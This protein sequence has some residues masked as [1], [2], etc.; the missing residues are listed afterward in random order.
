MSEVVRSHRE[1]IKGEVFEVL[2]ENLCIVKPEYAGRDVVLCPICLREINKAEILSTG[3]EHI[4]PQSLTKKDPQGLTLEL[5]STQR[6]G[7]TI[8]CRQPRTL[9]DNTLANN[10]CNGYKGSKYDWSLRGML[11]DG[12]IDRAKL[13][14]VHGVAILTMAYLGAFQRF[15]YGYILRPELDPIREQFD[16]PNVPT[17]VWLESVKI[18]TDSNAPQLVMTTG[19]NCFD[20][21]SQMLP[22]QPLGVRFRKFLAE[23]PNGVFPYNTVGTSNVRTLQSLLPRLTDEE[24]REDLIDGSGND[25][26]A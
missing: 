13:S 15:G 2:H 6:S 24:V 17:T 19:G 8:L 16:Y 5:S 7:A 23:L 21:F 11:G 3:F 12:D 22:D 25:E 10:G 4:V 18:Y 20:F 9:P 1:G 26:E 14:T